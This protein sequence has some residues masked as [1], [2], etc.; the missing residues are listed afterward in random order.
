VV[1]KK[2]IYFN[3]FNVPTE[4]TIYF[5]YSSGLLRAYVQKFNIINHN[6]EFMPFLFIRENS[7][8]ILKKYDNPSIACFSSSVWSHQLNI[9][10]A[11]LVKEKFPDCLIVFGGPQIPLDDCIYVNYPFIDLCVFGE[12]EQ[13]FHKILIDNLENKVIKHKTLRA[14]K[15]ITDLDTIPSPY[16]NDIFKYLLRDYPNIKFKAIIETNRNCPFHCSFCFWGQSGIKNRLSYHGLDYIETEAKWLANNKIEYIFCADANFGMF[17]RDINVAEIYSKIKLFYKYPEKIRVCYGKNA[18]DTIFQ[19]AKILSSAGLAKTVTLALQS[20]DKNVLKN[21]G[22]ENIKQ[23]EFI[24][25][26]KKYIEANIPTYIEIILGLPGETYETFLDGLNFVLESSDNSQIFIYHCEILPNTEMSSKDYIKKYKIQ[27]VTTPLHEIHGNIRDDETEQ[28]YNEIIISTESMD[29]ET[30]KKCAVISWLIQLFYSLKIG[31]KLINFICS[32]FQ[33]KYTDFF[34]FLFHSNLKEVSFLKRVADNVSNGLSRSQS[35]KR[36][37][38]IYWEPEEF[39]FLSIILSK[40]NFYNCL[41]DITIN[42]LQNK[43]ISYNIDEIIKIFDNQKKEILD[44]NQFM[45]IQEYAEKV[46]LHG[47]KSNLSNIKT[48]KNT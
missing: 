22:R 34:E 19:T 30:W 39:V 37:G 14:Q 12:G 41:F 23:K 42:F 9:K 40:Q 44:L 31:N 32:R 8:E 28:E 47:R 35:D 38:P 5:P 10:L 24:N 33:L 20:N 36:F 6:Y 11:R 7:K 48:Q 45:D 26:R 16:S 29:V 25:L 4:N 2:K 21:I 18:S 3:E 13:M 46:I 15:T 1:E 27:T 17:K 43:K